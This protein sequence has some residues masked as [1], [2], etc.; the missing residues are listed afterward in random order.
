MQTYLLYTCSDETVTLSLF[1]SQAVSFHKQLGELCGDPKVIVATNIN[2]KLIGGI[3]L[4]Q[5]L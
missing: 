4:F 2:P 3:E 5:F 1:D